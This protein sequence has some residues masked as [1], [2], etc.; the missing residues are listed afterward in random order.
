MTTKAQSSRVFAEGTIVG[1]KYRTI[2]TL[3]LEMPQLDQAKTVKVHESIM[4]GG[5]YTMSGSTNSMQAIMPEIHAIHA[6]VTK[7]NNEYP[8]DELKGY[9]VNNKQYTGTYSWTTPYRKPVLTNHD[10]ESKPLGRVQDA[11]YKE[12][13]GDTPGCSVIIP[14]ITDAEAMQMILSEQYLTVSVGVEAD[15]AICSVCGCDWVKEDFCGHYKGHWYAKAEDLDPVPANT[16]GASK[17]VCTLRGIY[18]KEVS[19]VNEPADEQAGIKN[20][21]ASTLKVE[22]LQYDDGTGACSLVS[23]E[24]GKLTPG[25][26][27][28]PNQNPIKEHVEQMDSVTTTI[29]AEVE[30]EN[31]TE[32]VEEAFETV[33]T[34]EEQDYVERL[35]GQF[36]ECFTS[37]EAVEDLYITATELRAE[38]EL[39]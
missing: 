28:L 1:G 12:A 11:S 15:S 8:A 23:T 16:R 33:I 4:P 31:A 14:R 5:S 37:L 17:C 32:S 29:V 27:S 22:V 3:S 21:D 36:E 38:L 2:E 35:V 30:V 7:N 10:M 34:E 39:T 18:F 19:F 13:D 26:V 9:R 6:G 20:L 24:L 25:S